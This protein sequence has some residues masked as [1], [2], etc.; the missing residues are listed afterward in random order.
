M[1]DRRGDHIVR[2]AFGEYI[3]LFHSDIKIEHLDSQEDKILQV[4]DF[5]V[6]SIH[7]KYEMED[8]RFYNLIAKKI[9]AEIFLENL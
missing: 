5:V 3:R 2:K 6:W 7:R 9:R 8:D 4:V 1:V